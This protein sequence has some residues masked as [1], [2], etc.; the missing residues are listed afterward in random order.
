MGR[1]PNARRWPSAAP[2]SAVARSTAPGSPA[3]RYARTTDGRRVSSRA[4]SPSSTS[5][6]AGSTVVPAGATLPRISETASTA[7]T[8]ASTA[9]ST[10]PADADSGV[11]DSAEGVAHLLEDARMRLGDGLA[12]LLRIGGEKL[13]LALRQPGRDQD[14]DHHVEIALRAPPEVRH[15]AA[16]EADLRAGLGPGLDL[17][18]LVAVDR[19][20]RDRR[21]EGRLGDRDVGH[22]VELGPVAS[23]LRVGRDVDRDIERARGT[24]PSADLALVREADLVALVDAGRDRHPERPLA[25]RAA[26]A[27]AGRAGFL[28][29]LALALADR[30]RADVQHLAEHR[31]AGRPDLAAAAAVVAGLG[32]GARLRAVAAARLAP[33]VDGE[34]DLLLRPMDG[35][36]ERDPEV[37]AEIGAGRGVAAPRVAA[38]R[39]AEERVEDVAEGAERGRVEAE[40]ALAAEAGPAEHVVRLATLRVGEDLVGLVDLLEALSSGRVG[41]D[42]GVPLLGQLP[43]GL[44]DVGVARGSLDAEGCVVVELGGHVRAEVYGTRRSGTP[45]WLAWRDEP[46]RRPTPVRAPPRR[47]AAPDRRAHL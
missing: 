35:L 4:P 23:E 13:P 5:A 15:A 3:G 25:L 30:A 21:P 26:L 38:H 11:A 16:T 7:S 34:L 31:P 19:R 28:D 2:T 12:R 43:E 27:L 45:G 24:A 29:D 1:R 47:P 14:V 37:V 18:V 20:H 36:F 8:S 9:S 39:P 42:V 6:K 32:L 41:V 10:Q 22:V 46:A 40:A 17:E 44:L 33:A